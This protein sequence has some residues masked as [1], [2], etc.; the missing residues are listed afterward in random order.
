MTTDKQ[1]DLYDFARLLVDEGFGIWAVGANKTA[2][3]SEGDHLNLTRD[4]VND[5]ALDL[6]DRGEATG[7][8]LRLGWDGRIESADG[9]FLVP[10]MLEREAP[11]KANAEFRQRMKDALFQ[12]QASATFG[13]L[14]LRQAGRE[15]FMISE[16]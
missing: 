6:I 8:A 9:T 12:A 13:K 10:F 4:E 16:G 15:S 5:A 3:R 1:D 14:P 7:V 11:S 2:M